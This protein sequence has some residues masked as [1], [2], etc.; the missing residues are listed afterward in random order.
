MHTLLSYSFIGS[1][2]CPLSEAAA[3]AAATASADAVV[4]YNLLFSFYYLVITLLSSAR[5]RSQVSDITP[6]CT[7][8]TGRQL[9]ACIL[10][11]TKMK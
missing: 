10:G 4:I 5:Q 11:E 2:F 8:A 7:S 1:F 9:H 6:A 3:A